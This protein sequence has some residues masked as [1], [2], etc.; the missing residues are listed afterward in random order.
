MLRLNAYTA[1]NQMNRCKEKQADEKKAINA[2]AGLQEQEAGRGSCDDSNGINANKSELS[3]LE[4]LGVREVP[5]S[6]RKSHLHSE[7][8]KAKHTLLPVFRGMLHWTVVSCMPW[9]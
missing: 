7:I 6:S 5:K 3:H 8:H 9:E 4:T 2:S 1:T